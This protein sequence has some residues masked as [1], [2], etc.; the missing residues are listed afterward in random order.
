MPIIRKEGSSFKLPEVTEEDFFTEQKLLSSG[1]T[2]TLA[3][4]PPFLDTFDFFIGM[5]AHE[6]GV[7]VPIGSGKFAAA[8]QEDLAE[9][10][11]AILTGSGHENR[12]YSRLAD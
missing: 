1:L 9:A 11:A 5:K 3:Y 10:H 8:C 2:F 7:R 4:H 6:T 12:T